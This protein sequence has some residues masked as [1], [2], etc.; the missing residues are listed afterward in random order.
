MS[1]VPGPGTSGT[2]SASSTSS[3]SST[4]TAHARPAPPPGADGGGSAAQVTAMEAAV[5]EF[6]AIDST[7]V[8]ATLAGG[9]ALSAALTQA[10]DEDSRRDQS[11]QG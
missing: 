2:S 5:A 9:E 11:R 6:E 1:A 7:D 8:E 3:T 4:S 10:L